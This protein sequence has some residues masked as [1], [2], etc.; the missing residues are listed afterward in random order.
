VLLVGGAVSVFQV[1]E[2]EDD[3]HAI[4]ESVLDAPG[5]YRFSVPVATLVSADPAPRTGRS[6]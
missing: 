2:L 1:L 3:G 4:V 6:S 5:R